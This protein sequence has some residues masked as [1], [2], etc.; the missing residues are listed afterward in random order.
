MMDEKDF[1]R[2]KLNFLVDKYLDMS[3]KAYLKGDMNESMYYRAMARGV[4]M[5]RDIVK[6]EANESRRNQTVYRI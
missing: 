5:A 6:E 1:I 4:M 3:E 2:V